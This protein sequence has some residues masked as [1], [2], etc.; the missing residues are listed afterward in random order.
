[1]RRILF[2]FFLLFLLGSLVFAAFKDVPKSHWAYKAVTVLSKLGIISGYPDNTFR[3]NNSVTR[4]QFAQ[5]LYKLIIY[6]QGYV[7]NKVKSSYSYNLSKEVSRISDLASKAYKW[8]TE[9][10]AEISKLKGEI[11]SLKS[12]LTSSKGSDSEDTAEILSEIASLKRIFD[13]KLIDFDSKYSARFSE[14]EDKL[15][16]LYKRVSNL[17][18]EV[19]GLK[20]AGKTSSSEYVRYYDFM[21]LRSNVRS[22]SSDVEKLRSSFYKVNE[23]LDSLESSITNLEKIKGESSSKDIL[24]E[25]EGLRSSYDELRRDLSDLEKRSLDS[26]SKVESVLGDVDRL[27]SKLVGLEKDVESLKDSVSDLYDKLSSMEEK[28]SKISESV[29]QRTSTKKS[30]DIFPYIFSL[31]LFGLGVTLAVIWK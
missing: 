16:E 29:R 23:R 4:Y 14:F 27:S 2:F 5:A 26:S 20:S 17:E 28:I 10:A 9:N 8:A 6:I 25:I 11:D 31:V 21:E 15:N 24:K 12:S 30:F 7:E 18:G 13:E 19:S 3:G 1:M 22:L